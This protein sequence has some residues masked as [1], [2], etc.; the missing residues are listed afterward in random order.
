MRVRVGVTVE[1]RV[2][3]IVRIRVGVIVRVR[4]LQGLV[5]DSESASELGLALL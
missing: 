5:L 3:V 1:V 4:L 2:G